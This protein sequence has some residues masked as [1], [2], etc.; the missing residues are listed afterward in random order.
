M[1]TEELLRTRPAILKI[2]LGLPADFFWQLV[3]QL[4][5]QEPAYK[6]QRF[7]RV[8]R[9]RAVGGGRPCDLPLAIRLA[10]VRTYFRLHISQEA[11]A[12]LYADATQSDVSRQLRSLLPALV[13]LLPS[14]ELW[15]QIDEAHPLRESDLLELVQ[16]SDGRVIVDATEQPIYRSE[17]NDIRVVYYSG[18][19]K[20]FTLKTQIVSD[21]N[22]RIVAITVTFPGAVS[23]KKLCDTVATVQ[24][25]PDGCHGAADKAYQGV[26][27]QVATLTTVDLETGEIFESPR[28]R[29]GLG[30]QN[31]RGL[32]RSPRSSPPRVRSHVMARSC[33]TPG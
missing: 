31:S 17:L 33:R 19:K 3:G 30:L 18:K 1:Y 16:L 23:D 4:E 6:R 5:E 2:F 25:L 14:P 11:V 29:R 27:Q 8:E 32:P 20:Q 9:Q 13:P 10:L 26:A 21:G 15:A 7:E 12:A 24:R 28:R 22:H